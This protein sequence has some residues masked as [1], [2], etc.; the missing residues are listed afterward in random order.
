MPNTQEILKSCQLFTDLGSDELGLLDSIA[1]RKTYRKAEV[2]FSEGESAFCLYMVGSGSVKVYK[3]SAEGKEQ[4]IKVFR[5][6]E[7]FAEAAMFSGS[8]YPAYAEALT[9]C[10]IVY[11]ARKDLLNIIKK[12]PELGLKMLGTLAGRLR[13]LVGVI[14]DLS[15]KEVDQRLAKY[16][17]DRQA[18]LYCERFDLDI[19]KAALARVIGTIPETLSR[20]L[21][22]LGKEGI[23][24]ITGK[25]VQ[26][27][28][29]DKLGILAK[30]T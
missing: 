10:D 27:L 16:L 4:I 1:V 23:I 15:L 6:G 9:K 25:N 28:D 2:I 13:H 5:A 22:K 14:E 24:R 11:L 7:V 21:H 20:A 29:K 30:G 12:E 19:T 26:I 18:C 3:L 17:L 8:T